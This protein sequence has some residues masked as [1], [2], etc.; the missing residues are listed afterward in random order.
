MATPS[1]IEDAVR[2]T[3][4]KIGGEHR[5]QVGVGRVDRRG[6]G[7]HLVGGVRA[8]SGGRAR[9]A[10]RRARSRTRMLGSRCCCATGRSCGPIWVAPADIV[11][12]DALARDEAQRYVEDVLVPGRAHRGEPGGTRG[13]SGLRSW[14]WVDGFGGSVTAPPITRLRSHHRRA[15]VV[16]HRHLGLRRRRRRIDGDLGGPTRRSRPCAT[17]TSAMA[18]SPSPPSSPCVPEYRVDGGP[19]LTLPNLP[20]ASASTSTTGRAAPGRH[21]R[22]LTRPASAAP[23]A[24]CGDSVPKPHGIATG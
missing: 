10:H 7:V 9:T 17:S 22:R 20:S 15:H 6:A 21:H 3:V 8:R 11:D 16:G 2:V 23:T 4:V 12:L 18:P 13:W 5:V 24:T 1:T 14:F 19:W